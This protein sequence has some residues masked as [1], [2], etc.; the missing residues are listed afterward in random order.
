M[1]DSNLRPSAQLYQQLPQQ[2]SAI[3]WTGH[4]LADLLVF[5][6]DVNVAK[7]GETFS[8]EPLDEESMTALPGDYVIRYPDGRFGCMSNAVFSTTYSRVVTL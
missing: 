4:N 1:P 8:I 6:P 2:V 5:V 7:R 3:Q